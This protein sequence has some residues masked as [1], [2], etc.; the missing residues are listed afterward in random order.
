QL[1]RVAA[2]VREALDGVVD[3][4]PPTMTGGRA[5][6]GAVAVKAE[7][8]QPPVHALPIVDPET[9]QW[10]GVLGWMPS[11]TAPVEPGEV[12]DHLF[13]VLGAL[14]GP[15]LLRARERPAPAAETKYDYS[16]I[17]TRSPKV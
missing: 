11:P 7:A 3:A 17:V 6:R 14:L 16:E 15:H 12:A 13:T 4:P 9:G 5:P 2:R 8:G 1:E 10:E